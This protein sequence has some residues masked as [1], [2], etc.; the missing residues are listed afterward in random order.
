MWGL[1]AVLLS[2]PVATLL[3]QLLGIGVIV[4]FVFLSS[5]GLWWL[6]KKLMGIRVSTED[7]ING[8]DIAECGLEAYPDFVTKH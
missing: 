4:A 7:E 6:L 8:L 1:L 3:S 5:L 2:N